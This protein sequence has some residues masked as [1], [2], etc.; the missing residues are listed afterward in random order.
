MKKYI[1][2]LIR[3]WTAE[4]F[5]KQIKHYGI[6]TFE[7]IDSKLYMRLVTREDYERNMVHK[8]AEKMYED[9]IVEFEQEDD[10]KTGGTYIRAKIRL[11]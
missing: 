9:G 4:F 6:S 5:R 7:S 8:L 11:I 1:K 3:N 10:F 2:K